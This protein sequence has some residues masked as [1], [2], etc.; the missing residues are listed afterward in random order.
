MLPIAFFINLITKNYPEVIEKYY[1]VGFDKPIRQLLSKVTGV[2]NFSA[3]EILFF[4]LLMILLIFIIKLLLSIFKGNFVKHAV[5]LLAYISVLYVLFLFLW[6]LNYNR[7]SFDKISQLHIEKSSAEEL[8][9]LCKSLSL[10]ANKLRTEVYE[11]EK[12]IM[13]LQDKYQGVFKRAEKGYVEASKLYKELGGSYGMPKPIYLSKW[14]SYTGITGIYIP[15]TG[16]ANVNTNITDF[17]L[18][19]TAAHEMAHQRGFAREDEANY[20]AYLTCSMSPDKD[21]QYSGVMLALIYSGNA[22]S[23]ADPAAYK[24]LL[25]TYSEG[26]KRDLDYDYEFWQQY[27]GKTEEISNKINNTYL[28][29]NGQKDGVQSYGRMVDLLLAEQRKLNEAK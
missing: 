12:G 11:N 6:G 22:L 2:F 25:K 19:A 10:R 5:S 23:D 29:S 27:K 21:F 1:A 3:A 18:P 20:I 24:E 26:V 16:E 13:T 9:K 7:L 4:S 28:K 14:L 15:Y 17:M 8:F